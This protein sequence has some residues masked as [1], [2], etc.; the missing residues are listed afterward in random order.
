[1]KRKLAVVLLI[2]FIGSVLYLFINSDLAYSDMVLAAQQSSE[3]VNDAHH[4]QSAGHGD[5]FAQGL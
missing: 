1:M 3:G 4:S 2:T 5:P